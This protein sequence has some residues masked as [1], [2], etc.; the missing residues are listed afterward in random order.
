MWILIKITHSSLIMVSYIVY[1]CHDI[2]NDSFV[3]SP[4]LCSE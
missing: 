1:D 3:E 2:N 4:S